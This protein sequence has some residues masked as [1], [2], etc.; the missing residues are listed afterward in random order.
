MESKVAALR[1]GSVLVSSEE[2]LEVQGAYNSKLGIWR[3]RRRIYQEIWGMI[4]EAMTENLKD[5]KVLQHIAFRFSS[6]C[7]VILAE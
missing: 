2:R 1:E 5:L 7:T 6:C 3:K 4:T